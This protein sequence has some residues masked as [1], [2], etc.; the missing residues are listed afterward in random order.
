MGSCFFS[1]NR[2]KIF[3]QISI[4]LI[5]SYFRRSIISFNSHQSYPLLLFLI[6]LSSYQEIDSFVKSRPKDR[7]VLDIIQAGWNWG[8]AK[9][10]SIVSYSRIYSYDE[11][12][13]R[14][15]DLSKET[16]RCETITRVNQRFRACKIKFLRSPSSSLIFNFIPPPVN[17]ITWN[18]FMRFLWQKYFI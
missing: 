11:A 10:R 15:L 13:N 9:N 8:G 4:I 5:L 17:R 2:C 12:S 7:I 18:S 3:F 14:M 6:S 16:A 1:T